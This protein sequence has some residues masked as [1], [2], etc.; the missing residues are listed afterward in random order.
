VNKK[1]QIKFQIK[2]QMDEKVTNYPGKIH[3]ELS[4]FQPACRAGEKDKRQRKTK[5]HLRI[6]AA[7]TK[8][9]RFFTSNYYW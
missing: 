4:V 6:V 3:D 7:T 1:V 8:K 2:R 9:K 5:N